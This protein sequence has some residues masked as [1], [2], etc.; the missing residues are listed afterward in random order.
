MPTVRPFKLSKW[1]RIC[2]RTL[3]EKLF[4]GGKSKSFSVFPLRV[5]YLLTDQPDGD[6]QHVVP[7]KMMVSVSKRHFKRAVKRNR[8][9]RQV[10]EAYRLNKEIVVSAMADSPNRQLLLGFIWMSDELHDSDTVTRSMQVL[11]KR[12]ADK[13]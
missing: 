11:L 12:I 13:L 5:V 4:T 7:V 6:L 3:L 8:V 9:K 2:G 1:E 10:R